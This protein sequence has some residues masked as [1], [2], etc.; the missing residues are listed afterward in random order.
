MDQTVG[1][2]MRQSRAAYI[3]RRLQEIQLTPGQ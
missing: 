2:G 1:C 3:D